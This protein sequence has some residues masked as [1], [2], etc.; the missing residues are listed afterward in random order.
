MLTQIKENF[1]VKKDKA[2]VCLLVLSQS[3]KS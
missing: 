3:K 2:G 1:K